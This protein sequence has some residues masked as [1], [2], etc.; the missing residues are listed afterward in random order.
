MKK[1]IFAI[2]AVFTLSANISIA[3][4]NHFF[5]HVNSAMVLD[6]IQSYRD[7]V[8]EEQLIN[9]EAQQQYEVLQKKLYNLQPDEPALDTLTDFEISMIQGD[10]QKIQMDMQNLEAYTQKQLQVLQE[11]LMKLMDMYREAVKI[12]AE[13][14]GV[15]YVLDSE[16]QVLYAGPKGKDLTK[17]VREELTRM[18][19]ANPV[20]RLK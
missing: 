13:K 16:S 12:V 7:L 20:H 8:K 15:T 5:A 14:H 1:L 6:S 2:I 19:N 18:D 9:K 10:M 11:R 17:E 4:E 3:Q